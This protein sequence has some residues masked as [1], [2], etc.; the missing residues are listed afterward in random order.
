MPILIDGYSKPKKGYI[1]MTKLFKKSLLLL[2]LTGLT[3]CGST[4]GTYVKNGQAYRAGE[5]ANV[6]AEV[7][8]AKENKIATV[9]EKI[10][11]DLTI[12]ASGN[13]QSVKMGTKMTGTINVDLVEKTLEGNLKVDVNLSGTKVSQQASFT[14]KEEDGVVNYVTYNELA[15]STY[16]PD[17]LTSMYKEASTGL[18]S[19]TYSPE[20]ANI[21]DLLSEAGNTGANTQQTI[22]AYEKITKALVYSGDF[23]TGTF[24]IG[25]GKAL[26]I[27]IDNVPVTFNKF[28]TSFEE[29]LMKSTVIGFKLSSNS[30]G[31]KASADLSVTTEFLY[32]LID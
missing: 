19:W 16:S 12:K 7:K 20:T 17:Q 31:A 26:T 18:Y 11:M 27:K 3:A 9:T 4:G 25:L 23:A 2:S 5:V 6:N 30:N 29:G 32:T 15:Y 13:G 22:A 8:A 1:T 24:E 10:D 21:E 28:V 14:A